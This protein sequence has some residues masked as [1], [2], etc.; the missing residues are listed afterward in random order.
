MFY[1]L[2]YLAYFL[3]EYFYLKS[4]FSNIIIFN[5]II[6]LNIISLFMSLYLIKNDKTFLFNNLCIEEHYIILLIKYLNNY[7]WLRKNLR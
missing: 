2:I 1:Y 3:D 5:I 7:T 6:L 4:K